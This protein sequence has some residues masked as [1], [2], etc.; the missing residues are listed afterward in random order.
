MMAKPSPA[1][2]ITGAS[3][4]IGRAFAELLARD[5]RQLVLLARHQDR[6]EAAAE[7]VR[8]KGGQALVLALDVASADA[9]PTIE[10]FLAAHQLYCDVLIANAGFGLIGAAAE[11][12][13][14]KQLALL[15]LNIR[16]L[17]EQTLRLLPAMVE[18]GRGGVL[19][20]ASTASFVP[21]P[22]MACY[23][24][25]K[26]FVRS[27]GEALHQET[28]RKGVTVTTLCPG[29]V[30]TEFFDR[31]GIHDEPLFKLMPKADPAIV[32][33]IGWDGFLAGQRVVLPGLA[34]KL[35]AWS[36]AFVPRRLLL[37]AL[38]R[39]QRQRRRDN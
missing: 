36:S 4:G 33:R 11:I 13:P 38:G 10:Q 22:Y 31:A 29:P 35:T 24:A 25:S 9:T 5:G 28:R 2:V 26:A 37:T 32:A 20:V 27:F 30:K 18:R 19:L 39:M 6:L 34:N 12:G 3:V 17:A 16:A 15:D 7:A 8:Q 14:E 21:G 23:Y 1:I